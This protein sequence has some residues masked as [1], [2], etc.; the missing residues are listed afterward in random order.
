[1]DICWNQHNSEQ[2]FGSQTELKGKLITVWEKRK[3][4]TA[5]ELTHESKPTTHHLFWNLG[6]H[7]CVSQG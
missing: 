1:V 7:P 3:I 6:A 4:I 2:S 5:L